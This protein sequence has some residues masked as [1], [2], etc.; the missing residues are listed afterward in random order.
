MLKRFDCD[1]A[2][3]R[4]RSRARPSAASA[5]ALLCA[6]LAAPAVAGSGPV[7][8]IQ[9]FSRHSDV[10]SIVFACGQSVNPGQLQLNSSNFAAPGGSLIRESELD[11]TNCFTFARSHAHEYVDTSLPSQGSHM[12]AFITL[13]SGCAPD[14]VCPITGELRIGPPQPG[15]A[16]AEF[17]VSTHNNASV[18]FTLNEPANLSIR[19]AYRLHTGIVGDFQSANS[20]TQL[21]MGLSN[22]FPNFIDTFTEV[23]GV[24]QQEG[25]DNNERIHVIVLPASAASTFTLGL[26]GI[27]QS[28]GVMDPSVSELSVE[29]SI[30]CSVTIRA[31]ALSDPLPG[32]LNGDTYVNGADLGGLLADWGKCAG[33]CASDLDGDGS[34]NGADL[35]TLLSNWYSPD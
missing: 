14:T 2:A 27:L 10:Q 29:S 26:G 8:T 15:L 18:T 1:L 16:E 9:S 12:E 24:N 25:L 35:G 6:A 21:N 11:L 32:D 20:F 17:I 5:A 30:A 34:V 31:I 33:P 13:S 28:S 23:A 7:L 19:I 22:P 3:A 4:S